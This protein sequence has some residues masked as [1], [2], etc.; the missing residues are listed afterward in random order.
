MEEIGF[1]KILKKRERNLSC[2]FSSHERFHSGSRQPECQNAS[3]NIWRRYFRYIESG[4]VNMQ[5]GFLS[6]H[7]PE[8][9][10]PSD[11]MVGR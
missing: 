6:F 7:P 11:T 1:R 8:I 4:Q 5:K 3:S 9:K 10:N 2:F